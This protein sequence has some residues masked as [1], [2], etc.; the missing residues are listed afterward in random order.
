[1]SDVIVCSVLSA[2]I[3]GAAGVLLMCLLAVSRGGR[4]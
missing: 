1:M 3:G 4:R 2:V